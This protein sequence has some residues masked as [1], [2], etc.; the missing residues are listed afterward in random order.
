MRKYY[1]Q[2]GEKLEG[3]FTV[4][5]LANREINFHTRL[6]EQGTNEWKSVSE[7]PDYSE[8]RMFLKPDLEGRK[9][10]KPINFRKVAFVAVPVLVIA[11]ATWLV[12]SGVGASMFASKPEVKNETPVVADTVQVAPIARIDSIKKYPIDEF[13][14]DFSSLIAGY[15]PDGLKGQLSD[16]E[17]WNGISRDIENEWTK[18]SEQKAAPIRSWLPKTPLNE[19][20]SMTLFYPFAGADFLYSNCFFPKAKRIVMVGLEPLGSIK[21]NAEYNSGFRDYMKRVSSSLYTSNRVGYFMTI[22]MGRDLHRNDLNGVLPLILFYAR[23]QSFLVSSIEYI[24]ID[25]TGKRVDAEYEEATGVVIKLTDIN[26]TVLKEIEYHRTNLENS[27]FNPESGYH[28]YFSGIE[29]KCVFL[30]AASYLM[31]NNS[32][33]NI[34]EVILANTNLLLQDDSGMPFRFFPDSSWTVD[35]YGKYTHPIGLFAGRVQRDLREA[36]EQRGS[37]ELPFK[38][39][40]NVAHNEPHLILARRKKDAI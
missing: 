13:A 3:P 14:T 32:F 39:G 37:G 19:L 20:D 30:K 33:N 2:N 35:L 25:E 5:E 23:R 12:V 21:W 16:D 9:E 7:L 1:L 28:K 4:A 38:I 8:I 10:H 27:S 40:Y 6:C 29:N 31:H 17:S 36:F 26:R 11:F 34:R 22:E 18:V 24:K 15:A